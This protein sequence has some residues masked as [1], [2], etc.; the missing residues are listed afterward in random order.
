MILIMDNLYL[1][2][3]ESAR[4]LRR[5]QTVGITHIV[6]CAEE[7]FN[8]HEGKFH[9]HSMCMQDPDP[10][11]A[12]LIEA[13]CR[14]ID[15]GR[16]SGKVLVHCFAGVSRSPSTILAYLC[17][18]GHTL[19]EAARHLADIVWTNPDISFLVQL[20]RHHALEYEPEQFEGLTY[21]LLGRRPGD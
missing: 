6:N 17:H 19:D 15:E 8:Y 9:Y 1:G 7:L 14:F 4:D 5:L 16:Q 3:R 12:S 2:N 20:A 21:I 13:T 10:A 11:F 18:H